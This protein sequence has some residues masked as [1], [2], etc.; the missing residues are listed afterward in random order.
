MR[1]KLSRSL[2]NLLDALKYSV[3]GEGFI[4]PTKFL[5]CI[6]QD[7]MQNAPANIPPHR[8]RQRQDRNYSLCIIQLDQALEAE[9]AVLGNIGAE[10]L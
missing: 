4:S 8:Q 6:L 2:L 3:G 9:T 10:A 1:P 5:I 7:A